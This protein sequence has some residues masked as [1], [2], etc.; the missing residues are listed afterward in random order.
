LLIEIDLHDSFSACREWRE[1]SVDRIRIEEYEHVLREYLRL[2]LELWL[3]RVERELW[4]FAEPFYAWLYDTL[5]RPTPR[6][7]ESLDEFLAWQAAEGRAP[8]PES[9][10]EIVAWL[11]SWAA[12]IDWAAIE[13]AAAPVP[14]PQSEKPLTAD[15]SHIQPAASLWHALEDRELLHAGESMPVEK[16]QSGSGRGDQSQFS[17]EAEEIVSEAIGVPRNQG[18]NRQKIPGSG[19]SGFR[20]PDFPV[21]GPEGSVRQV[22]AVIEVKASRGTNFG[23]LSSLSRQQIRD[24]VE[25]VRRLRDKVGLAKD[26]TLKTVL[27][28]AHVKVFSDVAFPKRGEFARLI[29]EGLLVWEQIPRTSMGGAAARGARAAIPSSPRSIGKP[30]AGA[31]ANVAMGIV[32][33]LAEAGVAEAVFR[34]AAS[35]LTDLLQQIAQNGDADEQEWAEIEG[36]LEEIARM[37]QSIWGYL[38]EF[39][40]YG[41][42]SLKEQQALAMM[43]LARD[44]GD[45][46]G[47]ENKRTWG[48]VFQGRFGHFEKKR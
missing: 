1:M 48:D 10:Q 33:S 13:R 30:G 38:G 41:Q 16:L 47:Y 24:A 7:R 45:K 28:N 14:S 22:G 44:L 3:E 43:S 32:A 20:I 25:F 18:P 34:D 39:M 9:R 35:V 27:E 4:D 46:F 17:K 29:K 8:T 5:E 6:W 37:K 42:G 2:V 40:S 21:R 23:D 11:D 31:A 12:T 15:D 19:P 26:P 36:Q